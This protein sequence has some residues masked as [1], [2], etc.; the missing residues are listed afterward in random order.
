MLWTNE[1]CLRL[2]LK[3]GKGRL[4]DQV[5][6]QKQKGPWSANQQAI[7]G[8]E[9]EREKGTLGFQLVHL[10]LKQKDHLTHQTRN[11]QV[12]PLTSGD[13]TMSELFI[14]EVRKL[15]VQKAAYNPSIKRVTPLMVIH[16]QG[17]Y[18]GQGW[19]SDRPSIAVRHKD[20]R[21]FFV[22]KQVETPVEGA[23]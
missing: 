8:Y 14:P 16:C 9:M 10:I 11:H 13:L 23:A 4:Q 15:P 19:S 7:E 3:Q 20:Q 1:A 18:S 6:N 5:E 12:P 17:V 21:P 2:Q 22:G